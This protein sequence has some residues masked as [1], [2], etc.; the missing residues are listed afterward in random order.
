MSRDTLGALVTF[1]GAVLVGTVL[2]GRAPRPPRSGNVMTADLHV[3][4][5]PGDGALT[6]VQLEREAARRSIDV[7]A[8]TGHN[9]RYALQLATL[10]RRN[11]PV[12]EV[13]ATIVL[14]GQELTAPRF[15]IAAIGTDRLVDWRLPAAAAIAAI[16]EQGGVAIAAH[17]RGRLQQGFDEEA[18]RLLDGAEVA[19]P[20]RVRSPR[21]GAHLDAFFDRAR[22]VNPT[23]AAVGSSDFHTTAPLG[24]CRTYL[25]VRERTPGGALEAI[26]AGRTVAAEPDGTLHG[27]PGH[28]ATV[29]Q[30]LE[31][32]RPHAGPSV[33]EKGT[34]LAALL[35]L[36]FAAR[37]SKQR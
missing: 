29:Q 20:L 24:L 13:P 12:P 36:A 30:F 5:F 26:R 32:A 37:P 9:N 22:A 27:A 18:L 28:V 14:P 8:L 25:I 33:M 7:I 21:G 31:T 10:L 1:A 19:H 17:P 34:A 15:H 2:D 23:V 3:H 4:A 35:A 16:Q 11:A 6:V